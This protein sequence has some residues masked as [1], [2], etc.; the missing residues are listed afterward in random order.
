MTITKNNV[1]RAYDIRGV[2]GR[3]ISVP[4][5]TRLGK[6]LGTFFGAGKTVAVSRDTRESG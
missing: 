2:Y 3:D 1:F 4:F 5:A 6:A